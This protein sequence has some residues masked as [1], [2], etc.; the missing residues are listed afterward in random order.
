ME[1]AINIWH[2]GPLPWSGHLAA[3]MQDYVHPREVAQDDRLDP[4]RKR[5]ILCFWASDACAFDSRP[6][7]RWLP[8]TPGPILF[9]HIMDA[10]Q[11]LDSGRGEAGWSWAAVPRHLPAHAGQ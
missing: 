7:F 8:G 5:A 1:V 4:A 10:L 9:D 6:G 3:D 2:D 11:S